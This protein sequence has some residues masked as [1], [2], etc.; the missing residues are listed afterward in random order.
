M[1]EASLQ[2]YVRGAIVNYN[3][4]LDR[5]TCIEI[6]FPATHPVLILS[7]NY[8]TP[9]ATVQAFVLSS[10]LNRYY[11]YRIFINSRNQKY[12]GKW[13]VI[14][15]R[16]MYTIRKAYLGEIIGFAPPALVDKCLRAYMF[17]VG[18]SNDM[19]DYLRNDQMARDFYGAG[20][21]N[22]PENPDPFMIDREFSRERYY[23]IGIA[24]HDRMRFAG[25]TVPADAMIPLRSPQIFTSE[26]QPSITEGVQTTSQFRQQQSIADKP[27]P[28]VAETADPVE[29]GETDEGIQEGDVHASTEVS[30]ADEPG[31]AVGE[32]GGSGRPDASGAGAGDGGEAER[33][34]DADGSSGGAAV[35]SDECGAKPD[36]VLQ[37]GELCPG[38]ESGSG[39]YVA[40]RTNLAW[41]E[42]KA[43]IEARTMTAM[44]GSPELDRALMK[45]GDDNMWRIWIC[46]MTPYS[47]AKLSGL[48]TNRG[49][50]LT[51]YVYNN[52]QRRKSRIVADIA[53][54][55]LSLNDLSMGDRL[56]FR[57][58]TEDDCHSF[59]MG[60]ARYEDF[61]EEMNI[62]FDQTYIGQLVKNG[63]IRTKGLRLGRTLTNT[64]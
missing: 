58:F 63:V 24:A 39:G 62:P 42:R 12:G 31:A 15:C 44:R 10:K 64:D 36:D 6:G 18:A 1:L 32:A 5:A 38:G 7:S 16:E 22:T 41:L 48:G 21:S 46:D 37:S 61:C 30:G 40:P 52:I 53:A 54:H 28:P 25:E 60:L 47:A 49:K 34:D 29:K 17:E 56:I 9:M 2:P 43:R 33:R 35:G 45:L 26:L 20:Y 19:P 55:T 14:C 13:S 23:S 50:R 11:G 27:V 51:E 59:N 57:C 8:A 4:P 3:S